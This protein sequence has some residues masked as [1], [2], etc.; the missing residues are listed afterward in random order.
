VD[1]VVTDGSISGNEIYRAGLYFDKDNIYI[2]GDFT[3]TEFYNFLVLIDI[4]TGIG[5]PDTNAGGDYNWDRSYKFESGDIDFVLETWGEDFGAWR[6]NPNGF[7]SVK[8]QTT[9]EAATAE[10]GRKVVEIAVPLS[11]FGI[12]DFSNMSIKAAFVLTGWVDN[13]VQLAGD[14]LPNQGYETSDGRYTIIPVEI[15][16]VLSCH[17]H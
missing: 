4:S 16:N 8:T 11:L 3:R 14:F 17:S 7:T 13:G 12:T 15:K 10:N 6:G 5:A 9:H 1:D 2:A